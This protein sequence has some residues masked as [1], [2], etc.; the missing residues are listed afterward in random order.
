MSF[1][2]SVWIKHK[3]VCPIQANNIESFEWREDTQQAH[4]LLAIKE[5][6]SKR[7]E[8]KKNIYEKDGDCFNV[9]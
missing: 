6:W 5:I 3:T 1:F 2:S 7:N 4:T 9:K 8:Y